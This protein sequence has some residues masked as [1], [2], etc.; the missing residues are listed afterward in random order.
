MVGTLG[1]TSKH[2]S[3]DDKELL[4]EL[5]ERL[6]D[7]G[8]D[9]HSRQGQRPHHH[10]RLQKLRSELNLEALAQNELELKANLFYHIGN[11]IKRWRVE[12]VVPGK[13]VL[14]LLKTFCLVVQV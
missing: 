9:S 11:P 10:K 2:P 6:D 1:Q 14:Q 13:L 12:K 8:E 3:E 5:E 4:I 7:T